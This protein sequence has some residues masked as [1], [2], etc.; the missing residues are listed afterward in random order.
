MAKL[1]A[2]ILSAD[3][4]RLAD[5]VKLVEGYADLIHIDVMDAHFVPPLTVGPAVIAG[6]RR[7][8]TLT[9]HAHLQVETPEGLFDELAEAGTDVVSF[10]LEAVPDAAPVIA[11]ARAT[12]M[13]VGVALSPET[14]ARA[15]LAHLDDV[16]D[17]VVLAV[18]PGWAGQPFQPEALAK[19]AE[20]RAEI[21][22]RGCALDV[23]V[24]GGVNPTTAPACIQ[25]GASV[26]VASSA[27][28]GAPDP[29]EA[30]RLLK[31]IVE[32]A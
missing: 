12:G 6:L 29:A 31:A 1:A 3:L 28:F 17:V 4:A 10:H 21:D 26:L 13:R 11:K 23:H 27:I 30:A 2:S 14:P 15:A 24:D 25:A 5:Q 16:D 22:R 20:I 7:S 8:T 32:A 19:V 9:L 18:H